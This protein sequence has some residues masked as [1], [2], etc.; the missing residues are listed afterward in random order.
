M[1]F[2][3]V[4]EAHNFSYASGQPS[5]TLAGNQTKGNLLVAWA[6]AST[7]TAWPDDGINAWIPLYQS[8]GAGGYG[9]VSAWYAIAR[10]TGSFPLHFFQ[11][12]NPNFSGGDGSVPGNLG[13]AA[14]QVMEFSGNGQNPF[15]AKTNATGT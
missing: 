13:F 4:Q 11:A 6:T 5:I 3:F 12:P 2:S 15:E 7:T 8:I 9:S 10:K 14:C 1:A